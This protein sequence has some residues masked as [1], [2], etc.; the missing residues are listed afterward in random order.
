MSVNVRLAAVGIFFGTEEGGDPASGGVGG[1]KFRNAPKVL[2]DPNARIFDVIQAVRNSIR[3][4]LVKNCIGF[5]VETTGPTNS[6]GTINKISATYTS[7]PRKDYGPGQYSITDSSAYRGSDGY[8]N[9]IFA[10]QT[11]IFNKDFRQKNTDGT[12]KL[13]TVESRPVFE[14]DDLIIF[15]CV[16]ILKGSIDY[17]V[18]AKLENASKKLSS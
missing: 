15:R 11:Y 7:S 9:P 8:L 14:E 13:F 17:V 12:E 2:V 18:P 3:S 4:G 10:W 6:T 5:Q 16:V 1:S